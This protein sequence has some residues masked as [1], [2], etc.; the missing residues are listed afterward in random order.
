[1]TSNQ[2][3]KRLE[4]LGKDPDY[5]RLKELLQRQS[6]ERVESFLAELSECEEQDGATKETEA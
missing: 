3:E 4:A 2:K 6:Q 5:I 1:M